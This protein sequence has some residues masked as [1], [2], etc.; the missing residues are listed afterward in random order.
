[1]LSRLGNLVKSEELT[2]QKGSNHAHS[3]ISIS[4]SQFSCVNR[5]YF[6]YASMTSMKKCDVGIYVY[7]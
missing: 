2:K 4:N 3:Y 1:M 5:Y 7:E 6:G